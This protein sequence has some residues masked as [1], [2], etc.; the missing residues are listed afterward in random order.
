MAG[1]QQQQEERVKLRRQLLRL[2]RPRRRLL[3]RVNKTK[4][5]QKEKNDRGTDLERTYLSACCCFLIRSLILVAFVCLRCLRRQLLRETSVSAAQRLSTQKRGKKCFGGDRSLFV[6][7]F[8]GSLSP[9]LF[10]LCFFCLSQ[11]KKYFLCGK[12][13]CF[14]CFHF[15]LS[16]FRCGVEQRVSVTMH[17]CSGLSFLFYSI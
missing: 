3:R 11:K 9:H 4:N 16:K 12:G 17:H 10:F 1:E 14:F 13:M 8:V 2:K 15:T 5:K 7:F 6:C